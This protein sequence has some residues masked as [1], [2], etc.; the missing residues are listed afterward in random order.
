MAKLQPAKISAVCWARLLGRKLKNSVLA[1]KTVEDDPAMQNS[2]L[3]RSA[4]KQYFELMTVMY[5]FEKI[6]FEKY[7]QNSTF[8][9][10]H[11]NR[12]YILNIQI[13]KE[14]TSRCLLPRTLSFLLIEF[15]I[16]KIVN[17]ISEA[18][19][20]LK[21]KSR[22]NSAL[23]V[24]NSQYGGS[25]SLMEMESENS[26]HGQLS[27]SFLEEDEG[28]NTQ[29]AVDAAQIGVMCKINRFTVLTAMIMW[30]VGKTR[31]ANLQLSKAT[32]FLASMRERKPK[33]ITAR[34]REC[35]Q[36][37]EGE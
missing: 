29:A 17:Y 37:C 25:L 19:Q 27:M 4:F 3:K 23:Q 7:M 36:T 5:Q 16:P 33:D 2:F 10:N 31:H 35:M 22:G 6:L 15:F 26:L 12:S 34:D 1:F 13:C 14:E 30:M 18:T 9:I 28:E 20:T 24:H 32:S 8:I 21:A 11:T